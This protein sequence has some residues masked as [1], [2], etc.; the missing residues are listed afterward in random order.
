MFI[1]M[2][3][4][5]LAA[6]DQCRRLGAPGRGLDAT[7]GGRLLEWS[8]ALEPFLPV[9]LRPVDRAVVRAERADHGSWTTNDNPFLTIDISPE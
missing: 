8:R 7:S 5:G 4:V 3:V 1:A 9:R 2:A 6:V